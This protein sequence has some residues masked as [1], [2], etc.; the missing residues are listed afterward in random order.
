MPSGI[1][2][3]TNLSIVPTVTLGALTAFDLDDTHRLQLPLSSRIWIVIFSL[4][5]TGLSIVALYISFTAVGADY[6]AGWQARYGLVTLFPILM[7]IEL[8]I[9]LRYEKA[10]QS[11]CVI[12]SAALLAICCTLYVVV[13][14]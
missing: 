7:V 6:V 4:F 2:V 5:A 1:S 11:I 13:Y 3:V 10:I 8:P 9:R 14:W 12:A